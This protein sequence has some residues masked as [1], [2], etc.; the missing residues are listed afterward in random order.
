MSD[1]EL[2]DLFSMKRGQYKTCKAQ[3]DL[4]V[5]HR[6]LLTGTTR[7]DL[8]ETYCSTS[9]FHMG[10]SRFCDYVRDYED[11]IANCTQSCFT[12]GDMIIEEWITIPK[13]MVAADTGEISPAYVF[14][15]FAPYSKLLFLYGAEERNVQSWVAINNLFFTEIGCAP[16]HIVAPESSSTHTTKGGIKHLQPL[17]KDFLDTYHIGYQTMSSVNITDEITDIVN[18]LKSFLGSYVLTGISSLQIILH[19]WCD[20]YMNLTLQ[21]G[22]TRQQV[23]DVSERPLMADVEGLLFETYKETT[24]RVLF[25]YHICFEKNYY[26]VPHRYSQM[27][28]LA[29]IRAYAQ[30]IEI[31]CSGKLIAVHARVQNNENIYVTDPAHMPTEKEECWYKWNATRMKAWAKQIGPNVE[32]AIEHLL[33]SRPYPPQAYKVCLALLQ[34]S[35]YYESTALDHACSD[36]SHPSLRIIKGRLE[37]ESHQKTL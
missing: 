4:A 9:E 31:Y 37:H 14:L 20:N 13:I 33:R 16:Q 27:S 25:N 11:I 10:Y 36:L 8:W 18:K 7:R 3:P 15:A 22:L 2:Q 34:L 19:S 6:S 23:F 5:I 29:T 35:K 24:T 21:S 17:F 26:S 12:P 1:K 28:E 30:K 32:I